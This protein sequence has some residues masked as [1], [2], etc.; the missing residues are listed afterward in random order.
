MWSDPGSKWSFGGGKQLVTDYGVFNA[1]SI[2]FQIYCRGQCTYN[3]FLEFFLPELN[4]I[5]FSSHWLLSYITITGKMDSGE[6]GMNVV[7]ITVITPRT[8]YWPSQDQISDL[9]FSSPELTYTY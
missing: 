9:L 4:T 1:I 6:R 7:K 8:E 2:L 3:A 5:F